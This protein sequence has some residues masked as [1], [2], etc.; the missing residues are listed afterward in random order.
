MRVLTAL[1]LFLLALLPAR[2][3]VGAGEHRPSAP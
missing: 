1:L 3:D 2:A